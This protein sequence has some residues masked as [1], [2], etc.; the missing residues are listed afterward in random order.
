[1][2]LSCDW[3]CHTL[4][5]N[6]EQRNVPLRRCHNAHNEATRRR[7][8]VREEPPSP[9]QQPVSVPR[10][11]G[12]AA[13]HSRASVSVDRFFDPNLTPRG[14]AVHTQ[15]P[16]ARS[17]RPRNAERNE[18]RNST[19]RRDRDPFLVIRDQVGEC[20]RSFLLHA[21]GEARSAMRGGMLAAAIVFYI[22]AQ[23][24][25][26]IRSSIHDA[27]RMRRKQREERRNP[28]DAIVT[29]F[30]SFKLRL[31]SAAAA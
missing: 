23:V 29:T 1:M 28:A 24:A 17:G 11:C 22:H 6:Y 18:R 14:C 21:D 12:G 9:A 25:Q 15:H 8:A 5:Y 4:Q 2:R 30:S 7:S 3:G 26:C 16:H 31:H 19:C 27:N 10:A 20:A 13:M